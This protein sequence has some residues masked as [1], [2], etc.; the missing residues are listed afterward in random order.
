[1]RPKL[2]LSSIQTTFQSTF[3]LQLSTKQIRFP[4]SFFYCHESKFPF[5]FEQSNA[6]KMSVL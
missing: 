6:E 1:M 5:C 3:Q 2:L 4:T